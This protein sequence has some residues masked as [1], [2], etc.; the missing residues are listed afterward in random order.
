MESKVSVS[1][2]TESKPKT[3]MIMVPVSGININVLYFVK[4]I[5]R[6]HFQSAPTMPPE[7]PICRSLTSQSIQVSWDLPPPVGR[8]GK[9][10]GF[11]VSYQPAEDWY[12][13]CVETNVVSWSLII[14]CDL[15]FFLEKNEF[16]TKITTLQHTTIQAL[17]KYTNY[18]ISVFAFTNKGDGVQ[19][20][21]IYCKTEEDSNYT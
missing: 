4:L 18:S 15:F 10:Q 19:S 2:K 12:G 8:N 13:K 17:L 21:Y 5:I 14:H 1:S 16:E 6:N 20:D 3:C 11:K 7:K 9:I